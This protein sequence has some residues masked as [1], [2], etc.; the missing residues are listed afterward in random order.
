MQPTKIELFE[1]AWERCNEMD[2]K[3]AEIHTK[4][5]LE[6]AMEALQFYA[7]NQG[8][9]AVWTG[10]VKNMSKGAKD[11]SYYWRSSLTEVNFDILKLDERSSPCTVNEC[12][13]ILHSDGKV[14]PEES[15]NWA[16]ATALCELRMINRPKNG[17]QFEE[18]LK[19]EVEARKA[20]EV[21]MKKHN[22]SSESN[23]ASL[24]KSRSALFVLYSLNLIAL[25][26]LGVFMFIIW[27]KVN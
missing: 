23:V 5:E 7:S 8:Y 27:R 19:K 9:D 21:E 1:E 4:D 22:E 2:G 26:A 14:W 13:L 12:T 20:L 10:A 15:K 24:K 25:L 11:E 17:Y 6:A 18:Q 16:R 3:L